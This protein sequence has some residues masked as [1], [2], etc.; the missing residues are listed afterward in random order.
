MRRLLRLAVLCAAVLVFVCPAAA[1]AATQQIQE[2][3]A[4][5]PFHLTPLVAGRSLALRG[6]T[7]QRLVMPYQWRTIF[8]P[9]SGATS[10]TSDPR[11]MQ[12]LSD[13]SVLFAD[14]FSGRVLRVSQAGQILWDYQ[15]AYDGSIQDPWSAWL[16]TDGPNAGDVI[17][18]LRGSNT[19]PTQSG[20]LEVTPAGTAGGLPVD[21]AGVTD[22]TL[23]GTLRWPEFLEAIAATDT[24]GG[25]AALRDPF[26]AVAVPGTDH[27]LVCDGKKG[28]GGYR[29]VE[30][31]P[32]Q[33]LA[34][35][36][37]TL[38]TPGDAAG[39]LDAPHTA[40]R[41]ANG[42]TL[43]C[44]G[45]P[46]DG[47]ADNGR[48]LQVAP[49]GSVRWSFSAGLNSPAG[50]WQLPDGNTLIA[51]DTNNRVL[52]IDPSQNIIDVYGTGETDR[53]TEGGALAF[54]R[55][56]YCTDTG[57]SSY[58]GW[59][60]VADQLNSR[61]MEYAYSSSATATST[62]ID[63]DTFYSDKTWA[64]IQLDFSDATHGEA[65]VDYSTNGGATWV[66]A[67]PAQSASP[68]YYALGTTIHPVTGRTI[69]YRVTLTSLQG[70]S[71]PV[72]DDV[73]IGWAPRGPAHK[74]ALSIA[75]SPSRMKVTQAFL[76]S[77]V[78]T[79]G[80]DGD[81]CTVYVKK[82][83]SYRWSYS[84]KRLAYGGNSKA[85]YW[86]YTYVPKLRGT[87]S[88]YVSCSDYSGHVVA[89]SKTVKV[90]VR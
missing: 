46:G 62:R 60:V 13:G 70:D 78:L 90:T 26:S 76:L 2:G 11:S 55:A 25:T 9:P 27:T 65:V 6:T 68:A 30:L 39:F 34:W 84:S 40:Q 54:P 17:V 31:D 57:P 21:E 88:F 20:V 3:T 35:S 56:A 61:V 43:I 29:V 58:S 79:G 67:G 15:Y 5:H 86:W 59:T 83:G 48:V 22:P 24:P 14:G 38:G 41:L 69:E 64:W 36:Y 74:V 82:P 8:Q 75:A 28:G 89:A 16:R 49:N 63:P 71:A 52:T 32:E 10:T 77:G 87:Y 80:V 81:P 66:S 12:V 85:V 19:P 37:G 1:Q 23:Q 53:V 45:G 18:T 50:A 51:D 73:R 7:D 44:D 72:L 42:D 33:R 4:G 47:S